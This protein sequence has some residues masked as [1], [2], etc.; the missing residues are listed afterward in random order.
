VRG[1]FVLAPLPVL[2][3]PSNLAQAFEHVAVE[4]LLSIGSVEAFDE[5][6]LHWAP[7]LDEQQLDAVL[8]SPLGQRLANEFCAVVEPEL[9]GFARISMS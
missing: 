9:R 4:H 8:V 3:H 1:F 5:A 2:G 6:V 7:R